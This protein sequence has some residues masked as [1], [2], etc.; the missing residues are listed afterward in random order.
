MLVVCNI[1][2]EENDASA[3]C[4]YC[5]G[6]FTHCDKCGQDYSHNEECE[7]CAFEWTGEDAIYMAVLNDCWDTRIYEWLIKIGKNI[8]YQDEEGDR[9][10][11]LI[12]CIMDG[13]P[14]L[15]SFLIKN[16]AKV[17]LTNINGETALDL[18]YFFKNNMNPYPEAADD[19]LINDLLKANANK[20]SG[21]TSL[22][23]RMGEGYIH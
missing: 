13:R 15:A 10:T 16:G 6:Y 2:G 4:W 3:D 20:G 14:G 22:R 12:E 5:S 19:T 8:D 1:C 7:F 11:P 23:W 21:E 17:I 18:A 9:N